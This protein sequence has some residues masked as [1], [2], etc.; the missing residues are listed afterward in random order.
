MRGISILIPIL[1]DIQFRTAELRQIADA[2]FLEIEQV[3]VVGHMVA[4]IQ[5]SG[6]DGQ[7]Y[8][9][10]IGTAHLFLCADAFR[11]YALRRFERF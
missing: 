8:R 7:R 11:P 9:K 6:T 3:I 1:G 10:L 2:S 4:V 5:I